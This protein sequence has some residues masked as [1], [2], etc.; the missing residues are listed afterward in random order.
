MREKT[1]VTQPGGARRIPSKRDRAH[2]LTDDDDSNAR[3]E[4]DFSVFLR[5]CASNSIDVR[6]D[7]VEFTP[8]MRGERGGGRG[9][10]RGSRRSGISRA[11]KSWRRFRSKRV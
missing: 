7:A 1:T 6:E 8:A 2:G 11:E 5:W 9:Q 10:N 3:D 4:D